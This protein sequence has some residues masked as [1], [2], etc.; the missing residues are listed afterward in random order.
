[1]NE[2]P[3]F[4]PQAFRDFE[5]AGWE[6]SAVEYHDLFGSGTAQAAE[7]L[8]DAVEAKAGIRLLDV[9]CG[10]G[11]VSAAASVRGCAVI[12]LDFSSAMLAVARKRYPEIDFRQGDAEALPFSEGSFDAVVCNFGLHH[13]PHPERAVAE[14]HRV[15]VPGGR[16]A[17]TA[18]AANASHSLLAR[19]AVQAHGDSNVSLPPGPVLAPYDDP[20]VCKNILRSAGFTGECVAEIPLVLRCSCGEQFTEIIYKSTVRTRA[21][22]EAQAESERKK[23]DKAIAEAARR[24]E[25]DGM[26]ELPIPAVMASARKS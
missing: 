24:Y 21:V 18:W 11:M 4:D 25:K 19:E 14:V 15:L 22:L 8:L 2:T 9:A 7:P 10:P 6:R 12:G 1:M 5:H 3:S 23:I 16:Y 26:I 17:F 13:F 20:E